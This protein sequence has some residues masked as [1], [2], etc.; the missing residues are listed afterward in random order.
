MTHNSVC[1]PAIMSVE[2]F[3]CR[4]CRPWPRASGGAGPHHPEI[5]Q[6]NYGR[7]I[8]KERTPGE[9]GHRMDMHER[10]CGDGESAMGV[11]VVCGHEFSVHDGLL[12]T[13]AVLAAVDSLTQV[14]Q[15]CPNC[16]LKRNTWC[17]GQNIRFLPVLARLQHVRT[18]SS[19]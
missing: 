7:P 2:L 4:G 17:I 16:A 11:Q 1:L 8:S 13:A 15:H 18:R 14:V 12:P 6:N 19:R 9:L 10:C 3:C 5:Q